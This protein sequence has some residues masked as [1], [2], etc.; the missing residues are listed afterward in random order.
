MKDLSDIQKYVGASSIKRQ[1][2]VSLRGIRHSYCP[3]AISLSKMGSK[4]PFL[5][6]KAKSNYFHFFPLLFPPPLL[7]HSPLWPLSFQ[8]K[9]FPV[10]SRRTRHKTRHHQTRQKAQTIQARHSKDSARMPVTESQGLR[11][12]P[13]MQNGSFQPVL[14]LHLALCVLDIFCFLRW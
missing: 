7:C 12:K 8:L 3:S 13:D 5:P 2:S 6:S 4:Y 14:N 1:S 11:L 10:L 9:I